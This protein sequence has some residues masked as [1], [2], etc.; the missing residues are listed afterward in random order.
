MDPSLLDQ[1]QQKQKKHKLGQ[2][3]TEKEIIDI[4]KWM[5]NNKAPGRSGIMTDMIKNLPEIRYSLITKIIGEY[6]TSDNCDFKLWHVQ[7]L[8]TLYKGKKEKQ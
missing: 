2:T 3:P 1:I 4:I 6:W 5:K 8:I 7:K